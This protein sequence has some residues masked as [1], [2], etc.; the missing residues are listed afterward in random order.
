[1]NK[2]SC[3]GLSKVT[4]VPLQPKSKPTVP[5][6][7]CLRPLL[8]APRSTTLAKRIRKEA[9]KERDS[10]L[11]TKV[12]QQHCLLKFQ[13]WCCCCCCSAF[14]VDE[15]QKQGGP[16]G[17]GGTAAKTTSAKLPAANEAE[18][19]TSGVDASAKSGKTAKSK[20]KS[21]ATAAGKSGMC[22]C[23]VTFCNQRCSQKG[24]V[25]KP[26]GD[27]KSVASIAR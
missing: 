4:L 13:H 2:K 18:A 6:F 1:M 10:K 12:V 26:K 17:G 11:P 27:N 15:E 22:D 8:L 23:D 3:T 25:K 20:K 5:S 21:D 16:K 9:D 14:S 7:G 19:G 24:T